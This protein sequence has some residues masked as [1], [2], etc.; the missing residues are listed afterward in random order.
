[1]LRDAVERAEPAYISKMCEARTCSLMIFPF[2]PA[3]IMV[4]MAGNLQNFEIM[5]IAIK[6][7]FP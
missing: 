7:T 2:D 5:G 3:A 1:L 6:H 4:Q